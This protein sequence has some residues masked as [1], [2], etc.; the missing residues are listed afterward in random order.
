MWSVGGEELQQAGAAGGEQWLLVGGW[1]CQDMSHGGK[2]RGL[3][4][5]RSSTLYALLGFA[6]ELQLRSPAERP[7]A[8]LL[9]NTRH[10]A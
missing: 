5:R 10:S 3:A 6:R 1:E 9:E 2:Q 4:G 7:L 8:Y